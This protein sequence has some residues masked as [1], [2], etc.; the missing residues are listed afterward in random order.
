VGVP[1]WTRQSAT[2]LYSEEVTPV[3]WKLSIPYQG[4]LYRVTTKRSGHPGYLLDEL[5]E[6]DGIGDLVLDL[7]ELAL[8]I[9]Q[10][11]RV[12]NE[13]DEEER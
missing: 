11:D 5:T 8:Q 4:I 10:P 1:T 12:D 6:D 7:R 13:A 2:E 9:C 3:D